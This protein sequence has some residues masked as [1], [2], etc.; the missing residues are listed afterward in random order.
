MVTDQ[1]IRSQLSDVISETNLPGLGNRYQGK[2]RDS[3][4][5]G[6]HRY[7][8]ATDR[9][10]C[11]DVVVTTVPFK[12]QVLTELA[13]WWFDKTSDI[14][15]NHLIELPDPNV[16]VVH[17]CDLLPV[18]VVVRGYLAGS[19]WR[20][21]EAGRAVSG[22][23]L[24]P[25]LRRHEKLPKILLTPSTK[26]ATGSHD[27][28]IA[29]GDII[30]SGIVSERLW[31]EVREVAFA[32]FNR[33]TV[34]AAKHGLLLVDTKYEFGLLDGKLLLVDEVHTLDSSRYWVAETYQGKFARDQSPEMLDKEP[35]R[36]WLISQGY[37]GD[38][39]VPEFTEQYRVELAQ[40]YIRSF[41]KITGEVFNPRVGKFSW[42]QWKLAGSDTAI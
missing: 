13:K 42:G 33:G 26:A 25:G 23:H 18:E 12:G 21:Y 29:E 32:L 8:I 30:A 10:S 28:P 31:S 11:F 6:K 14:V 40:H 7:L 34:E 24:P 17:Q 15:A 41:E 20:D 22:V 2:V 37:M 38:G 4:T 19:A 5:K 1:V 9:L 39:P 16:M 3:Y 35:V 36:Q 27:Q